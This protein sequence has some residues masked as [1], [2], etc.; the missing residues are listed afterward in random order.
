MPI[1]ALNYQLQLEEVNV[2]EIGDDPFTLALRSMHVLSALQ[3]RF[4]HDELRLYA[5]IKT[6]ESHDIQNVLDHITIQVND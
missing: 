3:I 1:L 4:L 6:Q 5:Y 2:E